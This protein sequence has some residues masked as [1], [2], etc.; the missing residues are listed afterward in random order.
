MK[1]QTPQN[2]LFSAVCATS[3]QKVKESSIFYLGGEAKQEHP[4]PN[5]SSRDLQLLLGRYG[6]YAIA[7]HFAIF[8][9]IPIELHKVFQ[10]SYRTG[11]VLQ[12]CYRGL[13]LCYKGS[14]KYSYPTCTCIIN[15][16]ISWMSVK[17]CHSSY[18]FCY[19][20]LKNKRETSISKEQNKTKR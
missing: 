7:L 12:L 19:S 10:L 2:A 17:L 13:Q 8:W 5:L 16:F 4:S 11:Q 15:K 18:N 1:P 6:L 20:A 14:Y 9:S 3:Q